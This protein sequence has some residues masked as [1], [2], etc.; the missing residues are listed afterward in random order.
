MTPPILQLLPLA[1]HD[2]TI[3]VTADAEADRSIKPGP[4]E[5]RARYTVQA[6]NDR[7]CLAPDT[8]DLAIPV[9]V[10]A[11][12]E[13]V[14]AANAEVFAKADGHYASYV[15]QQ[16]GD[17]VRAFD[18]T[19]AWWQLPLTVT[20]QYPL[21]GTLLEGQKFDATMAFP[22]KIRTFFN[23]WR[24]SFGQT[25][26][27]TDVDVIQGSLPSGMI[28]TMY[29]DKKTGLPVR[30]VAKVIG[31]EGEEYTQDVTFS[32]YKEFAGVKHFTRLRVRQA[33]ED[34]MDFQIQ[35]LNLLEKLDPQPFAKP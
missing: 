23:N 9:K 32:D 11:A 35:E 4:L 7:V 31:W 28:G 13:A 21:T 24:V 20:P 17:V 2:G 33:G 6:C 26:D 16:E 34:L 12:T 3:Y 5:I 8:I 18:G 22:W 14:K 1:V 25:I 30:Q 27:G 29:F 10:M 19:T 15:H